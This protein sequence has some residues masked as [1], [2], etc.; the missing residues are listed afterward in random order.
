MMADRPH[1]FMHGPEVALK[2]A[3]VQLPPAF[4]DQCLQAVDND[5]GNHTLSE[6]VV[7]RVQAGCVLL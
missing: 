1:L 4:C 7:E 2:G 6:A 3:A 5:P